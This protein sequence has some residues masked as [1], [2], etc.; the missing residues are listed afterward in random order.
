MPRR[1]AHGDDDDDDDED[2]DEDEQ[3]PEVGARS[4]RVSKKTPK[5]EDMEHNQKE[6]AKWLGKQKR[7]LP[8]TAKLAVVSPVGHKTQTAN[9]TSNSKA[10]APFAMAEPTSVPF[11]FPSGTSPTASGCRFVNWGIKCGGK[12][13]VNNTVT[14][15]DFC[16]KHGSGSDGD[17]GHVSKK[18]KVSGDN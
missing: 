11:P 5:L 15:G 7:G 3:Q 12:V 14:G 1:Q 4:K 10:G 17:K 8:G 2:D 13:N 6:I 18:A 9:T 16:E